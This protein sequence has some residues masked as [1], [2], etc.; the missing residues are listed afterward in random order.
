[1]TLDPQA[2]PEGLRARAERCRVFAREYAT[3]I[4]ASLSELAV[5]LDLEADRLEAQNEP[6][7]SPGSPLPMDREPSPI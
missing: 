6:A 7:A 2:E 5:E 4:G 1:M 3:D